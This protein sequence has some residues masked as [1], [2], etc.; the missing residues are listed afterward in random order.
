[1]V[2]IRPGDESGE[3]FAAGARVMDFFSTEITS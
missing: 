2:R 3:E 1:L